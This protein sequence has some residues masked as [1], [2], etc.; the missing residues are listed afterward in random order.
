MRLTLLLDAKLAEVIRGDIPKRW[1]EYTVA[2]PHQVVIVIKKGEL[3]LSI[4]TAGNTYRSKQAIENWKSLVEH[5]HTE[6]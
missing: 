4:E 5:N 6:L 3:D 2:N 1:P